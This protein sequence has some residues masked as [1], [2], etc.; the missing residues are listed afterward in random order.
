MD[1]EENIIELVI[2]LMVQ[3]EQF[4]NK[5]GIERKGIVLNN[6]KHLLDNETYIKNYELIQS[7]I[8]FAVKV[9]KGKV[10]IDINNIKKKYCCINL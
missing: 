3:A 2:K 6:I 7:F 9:S 10:K 5:S 4:I 1:N 8:D